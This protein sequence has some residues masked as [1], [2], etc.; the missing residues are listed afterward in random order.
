M[1][2]TQEVEVQ[3]KAEIA[4]E[5]VTPPPVEG[6]NTGSAM[7]DDILEHSQQRM[8]EAIE[9]LGRRV[10]IL[11]ANSG[12]SQAMSGMTGAGSITIEVA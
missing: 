7:M 12:G 2:P 10:D 8:M 5:P 4:A 3:P 11:A 9:H 1:T 6:F